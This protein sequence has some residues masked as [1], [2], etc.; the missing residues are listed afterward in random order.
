MK[1]SLDAADQR[2]AVRRQQSHGEP[3][4]IRSRRGTCKTSATVCRRLD[5]S[6]ISQSIGWR[7]HENRTGGGH[8]AKRT[9]ACSEFLAANAAAI[10]HQQPPVRSHDAGVG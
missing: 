5:V 2:A 6:D 8:A 1:C 9:A 3:R 7:N 10:G 4:S